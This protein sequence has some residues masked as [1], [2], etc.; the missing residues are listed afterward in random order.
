MRLHLPRPGRG[1]AAER[2]H[3]PRAE[4]PRSVR[5]SAEG[6]PSTH[7]QQA[8]ANCSSGD[9]C[10]GKLLS[11]SFDSAAFCFLRNINK[12]S[13]VFQAVGGVYSG[14]SLLPERSAMITRA[15]NYIGDILKYINPYVVSKNHEG[16][17]LAYW[18]VGR[19]T[20]NIH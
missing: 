17:Q 9:V 8:G 7:I 19:W 12:H 4:A 18:A 13:R 10:Q 16:I 3:P 20:Q 14:L 11:L 2:T 15:L 5:S 6:W 1:G